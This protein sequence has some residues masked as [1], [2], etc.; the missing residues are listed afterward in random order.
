MYA[1]FTR[2]LPVMPTRSSAPFVWKHSHLVNVAP[3]AL[4]FDKTQVGLT[5]SR[6]Y[7]TSGSQSISSPTIERRS[8]LPS[9]LSDFPA[10][11]ERI[12]VDFPGISEII[13]RTAEVSAAVN[14]LRMGKHVVVSFP[15]ELTVQGD[16]LKISSIIINSDHLV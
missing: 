9:S 4:A 12:P 10:T 13:G 5:V 2:I 15:L 14:K 7:H 1:V 8:E 16:F 3:R 6:A 11:R